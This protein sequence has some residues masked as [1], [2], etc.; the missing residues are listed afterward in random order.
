MCAKVGRASCFVMPARAVLPGRRKMTS[1]PANQDKG[2]GQWRRL[3]IR[4]PPA[5]SEEPP[6]RR[7]RSAARM[8]FTLNGAIVTVAMTMLTALLSGGVATVEADGQ[9]KASAAHR[10]SRSA[11]SE[12]VSLELNP[13]ALLFS[14]T[15]RPLHNR[16]ISPWTYNVSQDVSVFP[17]VSE[18]R[19]VLRGCLDANGVEDLRLKSRPILHQVLLLRR[20]KAS[21][22][23]PQ[24]AHRYR[25]EPRLVAVGCT[26]VRDQQHQQ[27]L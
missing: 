6:G 20:L 7:L 19:C 12:T 25:L 23:G 11:P 26:C 9:S 21:A 24:H 15:F 16:S 14:K 17:P 4:A 10:K 2:G 1:A 27:Q 3:V 8:F 18:A 22:D 5:T 13:D